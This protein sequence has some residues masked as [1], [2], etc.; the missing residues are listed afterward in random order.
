MFDRGYL[1]APTI[2]LDRFP[3]QLNF[4]E[5]K[6]YYS[7]DEFRHANW[8]AA[9]ELNLPSYKDE[10]WRWVNLENF[11]DVFKSAQTETAVK[12]SYFDEN[13]EHLA[14]LPDGVTLTDLRMA[15]QA[16]AELWVRLAGKTVDTKADKFS[17]M[18]AALADN[19]M[20][21][22]L[23]KN[24]TI[25]GIFLVEVNYGA[26]NGS[27]FSH[28]ILRMEE[29]S[30][31]KVILRTTGGE[32]EPA[33]F[34]SDLFEISLGVGASLNLT[35]VQTL[36]N[37]VWQI[38]HEKATLEARASLT[39]TYATLGAGVTKNFVTIDLNGEGAS[40]LARG[41]YF[42]G[43]GQNFDL[44]TQQNHK[45]AH[46]TS[47]L[48][49]KGAANA[50]GKA[51]WEGMITVDQLAQQTDGYQSNRNLILS[52]LAEIN[53]IPGLEIKA[54]DVKCSHGATVG[55][56][57]DDELFYL[58]CRGIPLEE[59][60]TLIVQGFFAGVLDG[61]PHEATKIELGKIITEKL[62][63]L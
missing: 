9:N 26:L 11:P 17:A 35:E 54:D 59:A 37:H 22:N 50:N 29:G 15:Q 38:S 40:A 49:Y 44:D 43:S 2:A 8:I 23:T 42:A 31:A 63:E 51:T 57:N 47:D 52:D 10:D 39:W 55:K 25:P 58:Q 14:V 30:S 56:L 46:T 16:H 48:L 1:S 32:T 4:A 20:L 61:I 33:A 24:K 62:K 28:H 36:P 21:M 7:I 60:R 3:G 6:V 18:A 41:V 12:I 53:T 45:A 19:G 27:A 13:N 34:I 5:R